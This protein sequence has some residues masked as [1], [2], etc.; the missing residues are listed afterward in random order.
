MVERLRFSV[1]PASTTIEVERPDPFCQDGEPETV[2]VELKAWPM[3]PRCPVWVAISV[4]AAWDTYREGM[5]AEID[6]RDA[7]GEIK[8]EAV[9]DATGQPVKD[10]DGNAVE[11]RI[12]IGPTHIMTQILATLRRDLLVAVIEGLTEHEASLLVEN[13]GPWENIL[14]SLGW[15]K[16]PAETPETPEPSGEGGDPEVV[17]GAAAT[18]AS[19]PA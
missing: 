18:A 9:K 17:A 12:Y 19:S 5:R 13:G 11:R 7:A 16:A 2:V 6:R 10:V 15:W 8:A 3:G 1:V 4:E 14:I